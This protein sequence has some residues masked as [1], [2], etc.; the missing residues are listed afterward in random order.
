MFL[1]GRDQARIE[2]GDT[3][4]NPLL[5][6]DDKLMKYGLVLANPPF[7][8][9]KWGAENAGSDKYNRFFR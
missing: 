2:W 7:S 8:L 1:H 3:L 5:V 4:N 9:K 6:E